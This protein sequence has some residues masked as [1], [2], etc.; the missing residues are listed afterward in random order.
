MTTL[1]EII[2]VVIS[3]QAA[4]P[5]PLH[6]MF[7][8]RLRNTITREHLWLHPDQTM[9]QVSWCGPL[10]AGG[11]VVLLQG[12]PMVYWAAFLICNRADLVRFPGRV[13]NFGQV[14]FMPIASVYPAVIGNQ[15]VNRLA[16]RILG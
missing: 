1:Q 16:D 3:R 5:P 15:D 13:K 12:R 8:L 11:A 2:G 14:F 9:T 6:T 4:G 7:A 10:A